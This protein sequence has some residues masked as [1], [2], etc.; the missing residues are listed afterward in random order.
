MM[1]CSSVLRSYE[2]R[3][4]HDFQK[5]KFLINSCEST[6][7]RV[8][9]FDLTKGSLRGLTRLGTKDNPYALS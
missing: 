4:H 5:T 7:L 1:R 2:N 3:D 8:E 9:G 6:F